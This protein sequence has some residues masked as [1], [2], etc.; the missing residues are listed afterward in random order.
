MPTATLR[1]VTTQDVTLR[2]TFVV[3]SAE[4]GGAESDFFTSGLIAQ[5]LARWNPAVAL[6]YVAHENLCVN[7]IAR[8]GS[9]DI[10]NIKHDI[11]IGNGAPGTN[12]GYGGYGGVGGN[13][14]G[15]NGGGPGGAGGNNVG[16][17][18]EGSAGGGQ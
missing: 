9:A 16:G 5:G 3:D 11:H 4:F 18:T 12:F 6:S 10:R 17:S 15:T 8:N 14:G 13:P 1:R 7:N 2:V